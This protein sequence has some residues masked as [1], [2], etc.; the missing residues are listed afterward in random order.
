MLAIAQTRFAS[1]IVMLKRFKLVKHALQTMVISE[2]WN[3]CNYRERDQDV[4]KA[5]TVKKFIL[6]N[7]WWAKVEYILALAK[8]IYE[9]LRLCDTD[10]P[11]LHLVYEIWKTM[12]LKVKKAIYRHEGKKQYIG[13]KASKKVNHQHFL[14]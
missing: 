13:M 14:I 1:V 6:S 8:P 4:Q 7:L 12:I 3:S 9:M 2:Q 10:K 5:T 11:T